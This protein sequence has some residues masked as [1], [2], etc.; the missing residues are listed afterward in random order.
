MI[1]SQAE[2]S[3]RT[4]TTRAAKP[5]A[6]WVRRLGNL[7]IVVGLVLML[8][9]GGYLG[10][11]SYTNN[12][13]ADAIAQ[14]HQ[15]AGDIN[16]LPPAA[17]SPATAGS[18]PAPLALTTPNAAAPA[19]TPVNNTVR[20]DDAPLAELNIGAGG[21]GPVSL[22]V[23]SEPPTKITIPSVGIDTSVVPI[24][25]EMIPGKDGQASSQ[26]KVAEY[27]AGHHDGTAN[28][29]QVGNVVI[30]GHDDYKGEV[31]KNLHE[32]KRGD[33]IHIYTQDREFLYIVQDTVLVMEDGVSDA[34]K[35]E[36]ARYMD[37][38]PDQTLTLI[39]CFPY[40]IDDHR[41]VV[42]AK[43]YDFESGRPA[44]P[45]RQV[46]GRATRRP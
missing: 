40:G 31:F 12:Q 44:G 34:Q 27:A 7:L 35:R 16:W 9:V 30:S 13:I 29:G 38:T 25:W 17:P 6:T 33:E 21:T 36:N 1:G 23:P 24:G 39:T 20:V 41:L 42:I 32:V 2:G 18:A 45:G 10:Y 26:W 3:S 5:G 15:A 14:Q 8:G 46:G 4:E 19:P 22:Q 28:P 37:P 43:P 11:Q